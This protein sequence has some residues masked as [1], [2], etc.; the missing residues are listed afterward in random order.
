MKQVK[1]FKCNECGKVQCVINTEKMDDLE[2]C[3]K[4][5]VELKPNTV[6]AANEKHIPVYEISGNTINVKVG[7]V[8]HPM[9][10]EHYIKWIAFVGK[11][12][13][14]FEQLKPGDKPKARFEKEDEF[15]IYAYCNLHGLWKNS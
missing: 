4:N 14:N 2:C 10:E 6:E 9:E 12:N 11:D 1:F 13:V 7:D 3:G 5:M 8:E 15:E